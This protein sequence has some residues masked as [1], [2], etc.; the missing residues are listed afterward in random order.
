MRGENRL[1]EGYFEL[2]AGYYLNGTQA[3]SPSFFTAIEDHLHQAGLEW[4][5]YSNEVSYILRDYDPTFE[6][7]FDRALVTN[8]CTLGSPDLPPYMI[9][10][11]ASDLKLN[12]LD[13]GIMISMNYF[14]RQVWEAI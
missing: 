9:S 2:K 4:N 11:C 8:V 6:S 3:L 7:T 14:Q 12:L 1:L 5:A 13:G 10:K